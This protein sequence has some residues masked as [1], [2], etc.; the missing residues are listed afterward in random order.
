M[1]FS[2]EYLYNIYYVVLVWCCLFISLLSF[3]N[4]KIRV[5]IKTCKNCENYEKSTDGNGRNVSMWYTDPRK[6]DMER[7][8]YIFLFFLSWNSL[9]LCFCFILQFYFLQSCFI[10][11]LIFCSSFMFI[12]SICV[13]VILKVFTL[14][15]I[16]FMKQYVVKLPISLGYSISNI[17]CSLAILYDNVRKCSTPKKE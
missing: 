1:L 15:W 4:K 9:Q 8:N 6:T 11:I 2:N 14:G 10:W 12:F 3:L 7:V 5:F 16:F 13:R 17:C